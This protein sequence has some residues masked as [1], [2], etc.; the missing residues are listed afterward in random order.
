MQAALRSRTVCGEGDEAHTQIINTL[1][2]APGSATRPAGQETEAPTGQWL[3][4]PGWRAGPP[5]CQVPQAQERCGQPGPLSAL[6]P[7]DPG[8][9]EGRA[10]APLRA[11][12]RRLALPRMGPALSQ[13]NHGE[14]EAGA[15]RGCQLLLVAVSEFKENTEPSEEGAEFSGG[16]GEAG[17]DPWPASRT[18]SGKGAAGACDESSAR[19]RRG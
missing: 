10:G 8:Q 14:G 6:P 9:R 3:T 11:L 18:L 1:S 7:G 19:T 16:S 15:G 2:S 13:P 17:A 12:S 4:C 5:L